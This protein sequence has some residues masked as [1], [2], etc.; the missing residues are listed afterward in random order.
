MCYD[1]NYSFEKTPKS[2]SFCLMPVV[3]MS[4]SQLSIAAEEI[5]VCLWLYSIVFPILEPHSLRP[6]RQAMPF[7]NKEPVMTENGIYERGINRPA[8]NR[9]CSVINPQPSH[10]L[11]SRL[12]SRSYHPL[13]ISSYFQFPASIF[14]HHASHALS[15]RPTVLPDHREPRPRCF[16]HRNRSR[17]RR[18]LF[19]PQRRRVR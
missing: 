4:S 3:S 8:R 13:R 7:R 17:R 14:V 18:L 12:T 10:L 15:P 6:S 16:K 2:I 19:R 1:S 5:N 11:S 9:S